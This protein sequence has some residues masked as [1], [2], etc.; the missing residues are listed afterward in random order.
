MGSACGGGHV[1]VVVVVVVHAIL[2]GWAVAA[3][4]PGARDVVVA[5]VRFTTITSRLVHQI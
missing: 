5:P 4:G 2:R 3:V 1:R